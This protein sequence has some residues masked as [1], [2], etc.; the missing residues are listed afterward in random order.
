[1]NTTTAI[2]SQKTDPKALLQS[3]LKEAYDTGVISQHALYAMPLSQIV[4]DY[5]PEMYNDLSILSAETVYSV[6]NL[7]NSQ[8][9]GEKNRMVVNQ[10]S[11][12]QIIKKA[13][14][15][16]LTCDDNV[17]RTEHQEEFFALRDFIANITCKTS[18]EVQEHYE[19]VAA[20]NRQVIGR[21]HRNGQTGRMQIL[22]VK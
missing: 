21:L 8:I 2:T 15:A 4:K 1:M 17:W 7:V 20:I 16:M 12:L 10:R 18:Q 22:N 14:T 5:I 9:E 19:E 6:V 3:R 11:A 13:Y